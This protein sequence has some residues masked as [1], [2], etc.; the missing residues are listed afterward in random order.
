M[1]NV[2]YNVYNN[3][4]IAFTL[5]KDKYGLTLLTHEVKDVENLKQVPQ[6][7][8]PAARSNLPASYKLVRT[9]SSLEDLNI[10]QVEKEAEVKEKKD[11]KIA[12]SKGKSKEEKVN[13]PPSA[14]QKKKEGE[15]SSVVDSSLKK[16]GKE[17]RKKITKTSDRLPKANLPKS[18]PLAHT[19]T[20]I[21]STESSL[22]SESEDTDLSS[23]KR[24]QEENLP[25][26][27]PPPSYI[28][29]P[30]ALEKEPSVGE[31]EKKPSIFKKLFKKKPPENVAPPGYTP[32]PPQITTQLLNYKEEKDKFLKTG[33]KKGI[34]EV[35]DLDKYIPVFTKEY[36]A[37]EEG[38]QLQRDTITQIR[39]YANAHNYHSETNQHDIICDDILRVVSNIQ[40]NDFYSRNNMKD[41]NMVEKKSVE[42]LK[43]HQDK[44]NTKQYQNMVKLLGEVGVMRK[45]VEATL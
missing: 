29:E 15:D 17:V 43:S 38:K 32:D 8:F 42:W 22:S 21:S 35:V 27:P 36:I 39:T 28:P 26:D 20:G 25:Q 10:K 7:S 34:K 24:V 2:K 18:K 37:S 4:G 19:P 3:N 40:Y 6:P 45:L 31:K 5:K 12:S 9:S 23:S 33:S 30:P 44:K 1:S 13:T 16:K 14:K 11:S 41:L